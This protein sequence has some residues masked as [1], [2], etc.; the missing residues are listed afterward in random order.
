MCRYVGKRVG[1]SFVGASL[2][3]EVKFYFCAGAENDGCG[4]RVEVFGNVEL[5][6][7]VTVAAEN[8]ETVPV[9]HKAVYMGVY[10]FVKCFFW[11]VSL[12]FV[13]GIGGGC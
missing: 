2:A 7:P 9:E 3:G 4:D 12:F 8:D 6:A 13:D 5:F 11:Y 1:L 10:T